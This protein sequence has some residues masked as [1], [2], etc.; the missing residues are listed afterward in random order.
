MDKIIRRYERYHAD[1]NRA[2]L[3]ITNNNDEP[4]SAV[5]DMALLPALNHFGFPYRVADVRE[6][7]LASH[8]QDA[9]A[10]ILAHDGVAASLTSGQWEE[11]AATAAI[12]AGVVSFDGK[13]WRADEAIQHFFGGSLMQEANID[14]I[15]IPDNAHSIVE[16][17]RPGVVHTLK[18]PI[19]A[20]VPKGADGVVS[21]AED[22]AG[23]TLVAAIPRTPGDPAS[24][25]RVALYFSPVIWMKEYFGHVAGLDDLLWRSLI[26]VARKPFATMMMP[27]FAV[28]RID[29]AVGSY[30]SFEYVNV[31][32]EYQWIPNIGLF[33]D[34][35]DEPG[36]KAIKHLHERGLAEFSAHS[37]HELGEPYPDQ[38]FIQH[39]GSEYTFEQLKEHFERL[40][41]FYRETGI[42]PSETVN[43]HYDEMG[44]N[45]LPFLLKRNQTYMMS[46]IP[47]G[48]HWYANS[49]SWEPYPY[50]HQGFNYGPMDPDH[51]FW[52]AIAHHLG[53][54][55]TPNTG[56]G[57]GEFLGK[58][59]MFNQE[60]DGT[61]IA[62]AIKRGADAVKR[63]ISSGFFGTLM[64]HEQRV[65]A[66]QPDDWRSIIEGIHRELAGWTI[67][68]C[69][70]D[71]ISRYC[72]DKARTRIVNATY[73]N[74][75][76]QFT[77]ELE[78]CAEHG[79]YYYIYRDEA[80][81]VSS[82]IV[83]VTPFERRTSC[84]IP[85]S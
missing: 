68:Y 9:A 70:Y 10:V 82:E 58:C 75:N 72:K 39:D 46:L 34:D 4:A 80:D 27:P 83:P 57:V 25:R 48:V 56:M 30:D 73:D 8:L 13:L 11:I 49:Y 74:N 36:A 23:R 33:I 6:G 40:D 20:S 55:K 78:G 60:C 65:A 42:T 5:F 52:N 77:L 44:L 64:T 17:Q 69:S 53:D 67:W 76:K 81:S 38:I 47:F 45:S 31:L 37:F 59:T 66:V 35:L 50:G 54:Y 51:R 62:N 21:L 43:I 71:E 84:S 15:H 18:K 22:D 12:G 26:W 85:Y 7:S 2:L 14:R 3:F 29:D 16:M 1:G 19:G 24:T 61:D 32:N 79:L 28:C 41:V 63:G